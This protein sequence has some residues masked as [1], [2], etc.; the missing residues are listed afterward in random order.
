MSGMQQTIDESETSW[1][2]HA[3]A[4]VNNRF[5]LLCFC[6]ANRV[7]LQQHKARYALRAVIIRM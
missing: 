1:T 3:I 5:A 4:N 6:A 7:P 2:T